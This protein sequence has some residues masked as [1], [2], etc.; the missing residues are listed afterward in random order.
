M[1]AG[2]EIGEPRSRGKGGD[3]FVTLPDRHTESA[4]INQKGTSIKHLL[5]CAEGTGLLQIRILNMRTAAGHKDL[6]TSSEKGR[7][8]T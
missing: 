3:D 8:P 5:T 7:Q 2:S 1:H 6:G 4:A